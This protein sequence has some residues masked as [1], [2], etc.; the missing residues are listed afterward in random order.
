MCPLYSMSST[1][2]ALKE[3][4]WVNRDPLSWSSVERNRKPT[5]APEVKTLMSAWNRKADSKHAQQ[6]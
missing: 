2:G 1:E 4:P 6:Q 3:F 5:P